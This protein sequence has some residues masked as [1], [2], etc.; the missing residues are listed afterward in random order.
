MD[1]PAAPAV[2]GTDYPDRRPAAAVQAE[3]A[4][5]ERQA[6][7]LARL[8]ADQPYRDNVLDTLQQRRARRGD[9][10]SFERIPNGGFDVLVVAGVL[11]ADRRHLDDER[12]Q[13]LITELDLEPSP[14]SRLTGVVRL[15]PRGS[16]RLTGRAPEALAAI[17]RHGAPVTFDHITPLGIVMKG[18][19]GPNP[20]TG[21]R[22]FP[23]GPLT[24]VP[25]PVAV[26]DTGISDEV[27]SDGWLAGIH[28]ATN[29]D[30]LDA[31]PQPDNLLDLAAGHG[32]FA[33]GVVQQVDPAADLRMY[34]A[35]D[36]DG[37]GSESDVAQQIQAA[38]D[39]G[40]RI[41]SLSFGTQTLDDQ[42]PPILRAALAQAI[43]DAPDLL[44]VAA[45]GNC[46]DD[47]P[48]Y[49]AAFSQEFPDNVVAVAALTAAGTPA[50]WSSH[51]P[52][53]T[54]STVGEGVVSTY[55]EGTESPI[56]QNPGDVFPPNAWAGWTGTSFAAPQIAGAVAR[57]C[58]EQPSLTPKQA[59]DQLI[60]AGN[61]VQYYGQAVTVLPGT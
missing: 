35:M 29:D 60:A 42:G 58:R 52:W 54:C 51:G 10:V 17:E 32:T 3:R 56:V 33:I 11:V 47:R 27:R 26:I 15:T 18:K 4:A 41:L 38:V 20:T 53:V 55:V 6:G 30:P 1:H 13:G 21:A 31:I 16:D 7:H 19:G 61:P 2:F 24:G 37:I 25:T 46:S 34:R 39:D 44:V 5:V 49:P 23:S 45:A 28:S 59:F 14:L 12:V 8:R 43:A 9:L 36:S 22:P 48:V 57:R 50:P 40:A